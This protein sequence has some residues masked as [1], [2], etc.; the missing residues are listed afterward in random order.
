MRQVQIKE[1]ENHEGAQDDDEFEDDDSEE[2]D[3][4]FKD[5]NERIL[6]LKRQKDEKAVSQEYQEEP[7]GSDDESDYEYIGGDAALYDSA[8]DGADELLFLK[9][10]L[11]QISMMS[12]G[13][14][15]FNMLLS[16]MSDLQRDTFNRTMENTTGIKMREDKVNYELE[17]TA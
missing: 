13:G 10:S 12:D 2:S 7:E 4:E 6:E 9:D 11:E 16:G 1:E 3:G 14:Q 8:L 5:L 17:K 15:Y